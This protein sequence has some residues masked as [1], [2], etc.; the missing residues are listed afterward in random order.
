MLQGN[1][2]ILMD[3]DPKLFCHVFSKVINSAIVD[4]LVVVVM[5]R[6]RWINLM[7]NNSSSFLG[8]FGMVAREPD[9]LVACV[10]LIALHSAN[11]LWFNLL[12]LYCHQSITQTQFRLEF[13]TCQ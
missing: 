7:M 6:E 11:I 12:D 13:L 4:E 1:F 9:L 2:S 5:H 3:L 10:A 8:W